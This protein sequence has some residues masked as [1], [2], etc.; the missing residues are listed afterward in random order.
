MNNF[1]KS[2]LDTFEITCNFALNFILFLYFSFILKT[3][4]MLEFINNLLFLFLELNTTKL[5]QPS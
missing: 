3:E 1:D 5:H 4:I 2:E